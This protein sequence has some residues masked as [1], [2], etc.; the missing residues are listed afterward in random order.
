MNHFESVTPDDLWPLTTV[1]SDS[2][3]GEEFDQITVKGP[4]GH[5]GDFEQATALFVTC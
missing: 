4:S 3:H 1:R 2:G 5:G